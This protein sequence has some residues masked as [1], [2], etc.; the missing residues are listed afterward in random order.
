[1]EL[2]TIDVPIDNPEDEYIIATITDTHVGARDF[3]RA[4]FK[5]YVDW[6]SKSKNVIT[7]IIGDVGE[8]IST[9]DK[10]WDARAI[11][12]SYKPE[13]L[14]CVVQHETQDF[15]ELIKPITS[16]I[17]MCGTGNHDLKSGTRGEYCPHIEL[18]KSLGSNKNSSGIAQFIKL[19]KNLNRLTP[20]ADGEYEGFIR[21]RFI[22]GRRVVNCI[23]IYYHHG[24]K[25][26]S[27]SS[28][29]NYL[30][31]LLADY[32]TDL[33]MVGHGHRIS[34]HERVRTEPSLKWH[35]IVTKPAIA[36]MHGSWKKGWGSGYTTYECKAGYAPRTLGPV[37]IRITPLDKTIK[38]SLG[39]RP[40]EKM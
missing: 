1:M 36:V 26:G 29:T 7:L 20:P 38:A 15:R 14:A 11:D 21:L 8:H 6:I 22:Q 39:D 23:K 17:S 3:D 24:A 9:S 32:H 31:K 28:I 30:D 37:L 13:D 16:K 40:W 19:D 18:L 10:R 33:V 25:G 27:P 2:I 12:Q 5:K 35:E 34:I 4:G